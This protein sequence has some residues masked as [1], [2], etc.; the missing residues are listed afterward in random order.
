DGIPVIRR[1]EMLAELMRLKYGIA[2]AGS[3]GK[4]TTTSL[5]AEVLAAGGLD[6]TVLVGGRALT[7]GANAILGRGEYLVAEADES[8]GS[9]LQLVPAIAVVTNMDLE[10]VDYYPDLAALRAAFAVFLAK[11]P[12]YGACILCGDDPEVRALI[13]GLD[14]KVIT[15]GLN[16]GADVRGVPDDERAMSATVL[17]GEREMGRLQLRLAGRHNLSNALAA[18]AV[19]MELGVPFGQTAQALAGF[20]GVGRRYEDRGEHGGVLVVDDYG[21]HP[22]ELA[23]TLRVA[24]TSGRRVVV[25]FQ[26]HRFTRTR[27]FHAQFAAALAAADHVGLLPVYAASEEPL[28]GVDSGLIAGAMA[29]LGF[30]AVDL[31][32]GADAIDRWLDDR[33]E[34]GDLLVTLGAGDIGRR[35]AGIC[36]HLD[37]RSDR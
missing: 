4:T 18:V 17:V 5:V 11:V 30:A 16:P 34:P 12:F 36:G 13:P 27:H 21:H 7:T 14:R 2:V 26:P 15:Y 9:F 10:H 8:D 29:R 25:L 37:G 1:A 22:T 35:V 3:H 24:R 6:P 33:L 32:E 19:G 28:V 23:A 20:A 31:L